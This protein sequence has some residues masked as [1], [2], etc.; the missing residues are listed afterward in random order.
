MV[1]C[2]IA[3]SQHR[4]GSVLDERRPGDFTGS[5]DLLQEQFVGLLDFAEEQCTEK[6][7]RQRRKSTYT[8]ADDFSVP[9][10]PLT[11]KR[12]AIVMRMLVLDLSGYKARSADSRASAGS[13]AIL[14]RRLRV[15]G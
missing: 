5:S 13:G 2:M 4:Y 15:L 9:A 12:R 3:H 7:G 14:C 10:L 1:L 6:A 8:R 11:A